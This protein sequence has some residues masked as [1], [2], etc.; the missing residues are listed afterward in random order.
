[1]IMIKFFLIIIKT[2]INKIINHKNWINKI[3]ILKKIKI[4]MRKALH[5]I[6]LKINK[7][8]NNNQTL[9]YKNNSNNNDKDQILYNGE[10]IHVHL[11]QF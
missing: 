8:V 2:K 4:K 5:I 11:M 3:V 1:M 7:K 10:K 6:I 9:I